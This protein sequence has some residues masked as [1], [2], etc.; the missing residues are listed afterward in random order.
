MNNPAEL[1]STAFHP[2]GPPWCSGK[3]A[4]QNKKQE[5]FFL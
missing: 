4:K 1:N 3:Q 5:S 2:V